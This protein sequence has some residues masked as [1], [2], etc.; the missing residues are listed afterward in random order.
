MGGYYW[1]ATNTPQTAVVAAHP[2]HRVNG[3]GETVES[4]NFLS[5]LTRRPAYLQRVE[6]YGLSDAAGRREI[7]LRLFEAD[8]VGAVMDAVKE[9]TFDYLL[10]YRDTPP[11]MD[12][13]CCLTLVFDREIKIY[14]RD[15]P[16][17]HGSRSLR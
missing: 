10:V 15:A 14:H 3:D 16:P 9:A 13:S 5:G 2:R 4:T 6:A 8:A 12:L 1:I 11:R 7:L 17:N